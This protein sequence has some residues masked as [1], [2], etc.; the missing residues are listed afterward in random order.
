MFLYFY[1]KFMFT[2]CLPLAVWK[3]NLLGSV[4][5]RRKP[6]SGKDCHS[7][8]EKQSR[9][10]TQSFDK[11]STILTWEDV[12][13]KTLLAAK[14]WFFSS[15]MKKENLYNWRLTGKITMVS[16][17]LHLKKW[18]RSKWTFDSV[19]TYRSHYRGLPMKHW[20]KQKNLNYNMC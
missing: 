2:L 13:N 1:F 12:V 18:T 7:S 14:C 9:F 6:H 16:L 8:A 5:S 4:W 10:G 19:S 3:G 20:N 15:K 17:D 11:F